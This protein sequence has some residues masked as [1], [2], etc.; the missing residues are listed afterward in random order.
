MADTKEDLTGEVLPFLLKGRMVPF[1]VEKDRGRV[2]SLVSVDLH[3]R[4]TVLRSTWKKQQRI[5]D[6]HRATESG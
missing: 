5:L 3:H 2:L 1:Q 4:A 6:K